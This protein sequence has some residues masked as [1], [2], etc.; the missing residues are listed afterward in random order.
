MP[1]GPSQRSISLVIDSNAAGDFRTGCILRYIAYA[2]T[3]HTIVDLNDSNDTSVEVTKRYV[4]LNGQMV[5]T[6]QDR[7][8]NE[9][10][11]DKTVPFVPKQVAVD[12]SCPNGQTSCTSDEV[13][14]TSNWYKYGFFTL[15]VL[16]VLAGV[17]IFG[18]T[19]KS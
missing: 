16:A 13:V 5:D 12:A 3:T 4:R 17:Y 7:D 14:V 1:S 11:L 19:S 6:P 2:E 15:A 9:L 10:R 8:Y 18:R